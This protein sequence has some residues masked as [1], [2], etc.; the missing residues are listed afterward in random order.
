MN[1]NG[2]IIPETKNFFNWSNVRSLKLKYP[3][4]DFDNIKPCMNIKPDLTDSIC[5]V[6][7]IINPNTTVYIDLPSTETI[8]NHQNYKTTHH[9]KKQFYIFITERG[10]VTVGLIVILGIKEY[11]KPVEWE[12]PLSISKI[13]YPIVSKKYWEDQTDTPR[14]TYWKWKELYKLY[15]QL[16]FINV[17]EELSYNL[18]KYIIDKI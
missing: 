7:R 10:C 13:V 12:E 5:N 16:I 14:G 4:Y 17:V 11:N 3:K 15:K 9:Q 1:V 2:I 6:A 18:T 8:T